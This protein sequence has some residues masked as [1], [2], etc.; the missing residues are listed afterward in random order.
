MSIWKGLKGMFLDPDHQWRQLFTI[1]LS[2]GL[3]MFLGAGSVIIDADNMLGKVVG[4][5]MFVFGLILCLISILGIFD[6]AEPVQAEKAAPAC[7][8]DM[9]E[10]NKKDLPQF[11]SAYR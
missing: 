9:D 8:P 10:H 3:A 5:P 6:D 2:I 7:K 4:L 11:T 1:S